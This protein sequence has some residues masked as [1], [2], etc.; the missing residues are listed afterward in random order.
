MQVEY[1]C[2]GLSEEDAVKLYGE[3]KVETY[4]FEF[5]TLEHQVG[6]DRVP[7]ALHV[8]VLSC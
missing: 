3:D 4:L 2:C 7:D 8:G 5:G 1:G 6:A